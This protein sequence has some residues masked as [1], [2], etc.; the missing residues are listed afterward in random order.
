MKITALKNLVFGSKLVASGDSI[1]LPDAD[2][3][4]LVEAELAEKFS[5]PKPEGS[6]EGT[7]K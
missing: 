5:K 7:G 3:K 2:A 1:D 6:G 4:A